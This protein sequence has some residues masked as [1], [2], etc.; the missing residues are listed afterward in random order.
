VPQ[1]G[2][3]LIEVLVALMICAFTLLG[4]V[5]M[6]IRATSA[7]FE[8]G[9]RGEALVLVEDMVNRIATNR[10]NA[11]QYVTAG[12]I[13]GGA[14]ED[15]SGRLG[16]ALDL[17]EWANLLRGRT[18]VDGARQL[19]AMTDA[20]GCIVRSAGATDRYLVAVSWSG[21]T[22]TG[23]PAGNCGQGDAVFPDERLRRTVSSTICIAQLSGSAAS[24]PTARC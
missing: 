11:A 2:A 20:R 21:V 6:Q 15:C 14:L 1:L 13:G 19:G 3:L 18:E 8:A 12:L 22:P 10:A 17:C 7:E 23:A 4:L 16:A 9:Q 5:A 24:A